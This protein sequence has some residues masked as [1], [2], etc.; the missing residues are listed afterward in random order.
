[1]TTTPPE[2]TPE[3]RGLFRDFVRLVYEMDWCR[4]VQR[5]RAQAHT[6]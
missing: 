6:V 1:M 4:F 5:Y 2:V 3:H